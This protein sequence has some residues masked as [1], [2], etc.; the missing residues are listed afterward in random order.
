MK[1]AALLSGGL[2]FTILE[3]LLDR[4]DLQCVFT[5]AGSEKLAEKCREKKIPLFVGNPRKGR[6]SEFLKQYPVDILV[7]VNYLFLID[8][9]MIRLPRVAAFNIHGSLLPKYRGR[10]PHVWAIINNEQYAGIT[11]HL[12]EVGCDTGDILK[13]I[14]VPIEP[15]DT[16]ASILGKYAPLYSGLVDAVLEGFRKG[17]WEAIPQE[18]EKATFF[19]KRVPEDGQINWNWQ[20]ERIRNWVRAQSEPYPGAFTYCGEEKIT[21]DWIEFSDHGFTDTMPNGMILSL[22]PFHVKT[23]NGVVELT[24]VRPHAAKPEPGNVLK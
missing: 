16:G 17:E 14:P 2:G 12:I 6:G 8:E 3:R 24:R 11:A 21:V 10:T 23:P 18:E 9:E 5:D 22:S 7:S 15:D 13:Q 4:Y 20:K 1:L 19:G